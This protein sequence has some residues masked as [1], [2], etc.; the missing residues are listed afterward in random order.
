LKLSLQEGGIYDKKYVGGPGRNGGSGRDSEE[1]FKWLASQGM[2]M[3][4]ERAKEGVWW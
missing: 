2:G 3:M 4:V 1:M